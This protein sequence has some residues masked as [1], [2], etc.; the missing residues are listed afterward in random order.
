M[1]IILS[2]DRIFELTEEDIREI[3]KMIF[4]KS[5]AVNLVVSK[6]KALVVNQLYDILTTD[7]GMS[8][9]IRDKYH[10]A[11]LSLLEAINNPGEPL[12]AVFDENLNGGVL[13]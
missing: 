9:H 11:I 5:I 10:H 8:R 2:G 7:I 6:D 1:K 4:T 12:T 3:Y 13:P